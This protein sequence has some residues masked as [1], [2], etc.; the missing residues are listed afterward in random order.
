M[1]LV[2]SL[3]LLALASADYLAFTQYSPGAC[4][5][6]QALSSS[7]FSLQQCSNNG[8]AGYF[9]AIAC[10]NSTAF[11]ESL[12]ASP[13]CSGAPLSSTVVVT[14]PGPGCMSDTTSLC[15]SGA[16]T[17]PTQDNIGALSYATSAANGTGVDACP[18][19][20][21]AVL[22]SA[23]FSF[24]PC[25]NAPTPNPANPYNSVRSSCNATGSLL[26][27]HKDVDCAGAVVSVDFTPSSDFEGCTTTGNY[28]PPGRAAVV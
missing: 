2:L 13:T 8:T 17:A 24:L 15:I 9:N 11:R 7:L 21:S 16:W 26:L 27:F 6:T 19:P 25:E 10:L 3:S 4:L 20:P 14:Q 1:L 5:P 18:I 23:T 12:Y 22:T 28:V